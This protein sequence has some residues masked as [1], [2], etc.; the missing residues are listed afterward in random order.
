MSAS[1]AILIVDDD[2][3]LRRTVSYHLRKEGYGVLEARNGKEMRQRLEKESIDLVILDLMLP[4]DDGLTLARQLRS[5]S[6]VA[7]IMLTGKVETIDKVVGLEVGA[8]D[9]VTKPFDSR[10]LLARVRTVLRRAPGAEKHGTASAIMSAHF[11][12]WRLDLVTQDLVSPGGKPVHLTSHQFQLLASL[13]TEADR[14]LSRTE[15]SNSISGRDWSPLNRSVDVLVAKLRQKIEKDHRAP[16]LI[17]TVRGI[18]YKFAAR[19]ELQ[20]ATDTDD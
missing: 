19:V 15:I 12:G 5:Q 18:G 14:P 9:Y 20:Q 13:V 2:E 16:R 11:D 3:R 7:I 8:D 1:A 6:N 17:K 10:E 4:D